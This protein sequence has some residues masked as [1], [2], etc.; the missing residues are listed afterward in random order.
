MSTADRIE[1]VGG[2]EDTASA[3]VSLPLP[4]VEVFNF[5]CDIERLLRLNPLLAIDRWVP[6]EG[7]FRFAGHN[8]SND[9]RFDLG[10]CVGI[11]P[12]ALRIDLRYDAGL[13]QATALRVEPMAGGARLVVVERYPRIEDA[14]DPR[15]AEVDRSLIPWA[16]ALRRHLLA[17]R[18]WNRLPLLSLLWAWWAE[19]FLPTM[20]PRQRRIARLLL[21]TSLAEFAVFL[22]LVLLLR[23]AA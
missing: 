14:G 11:A 16:A 21:W 10:V 2:T 15:V 6:A 3:E 17:R 12:D 8:E 22:A 13:K 5:L 19:R 23:Y 9:R 7:G 4:P 20:P 1:T 18:R